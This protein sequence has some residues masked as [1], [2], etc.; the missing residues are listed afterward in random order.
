MPK[1]PDSIRLSVNMNVET[2]AALKECAVT[3]KISVTEAVRRVISLA[4][5]IETEIGQGK[6]VIIRDEKTGKEQELILM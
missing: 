3:N 1:K 6:K 2:A 5:F 4:H